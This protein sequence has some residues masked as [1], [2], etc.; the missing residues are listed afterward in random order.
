ME[1]RTNGLFDMTTRSHFSSVPE[2][3]RTEIKTTAAK[4]SKNKPT[5]AKLTARPKSTLSTLTKAKLA[6]TRS[7]SRNTNR[8]VLTNQMKPLTVRETIP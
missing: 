2:T 6:T 7:T 3:K 5:Y 8:S 4:K 1:N